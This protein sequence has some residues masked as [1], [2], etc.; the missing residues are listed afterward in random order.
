VDAA[1]D[2]GEAR[3]ALQPVLDLAACSGPRV[4][5][6]GFYALSDPGHDYPHRAAWPYV[7]ALL[8]AFGS[9]RLLWASDFSPC[10]DWLSFPQTLGLF[11][12]MPFLDDQARHRIEGPNLLDLLAE[13]RAPPRP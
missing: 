1:P 8:E 5:L 3:K 6:S 7:E 2:P 10:L 12:L 13:V 9:G 11:A 4:K